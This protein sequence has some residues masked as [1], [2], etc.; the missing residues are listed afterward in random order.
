M[1]GSD[2]ADMYQDMFDD[3]LAIQMSKGKGLGLADMLSGS[4][5]VRSLSSA[6][7]R[8]EQRRAFRPDSD[9][10]FQRRLHS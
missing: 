9:R 1:F 2:Q 10:R 3:Q 4:C 6:R 8:R 5:K 7:G